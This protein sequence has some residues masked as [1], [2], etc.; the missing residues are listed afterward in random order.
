[1]H[2]DII[3][4]YHTCRSTN[5]VISKPTQMDTSNF[6]LKLNTNRKVEVYEFIVHSH[7]FSACIE[8]TEQNR[9]IFVYFESIFGALAMDGR[10]MQNRETGVCWGV[11]NPYEHVV[12]LMDG[13]TIHQPSVTVA[14]NSIAQTENNAQLDYSGIIPG[15]WRARKSHTY[16][17]KLELWFAQT[18][19]GCTRSWLVVSENKFTF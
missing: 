4:K 19:S 18:A 2:Y 14:D 5:A 17:R 10:V 15:K 16:G 1:M 3:F 11:N 13:Q 12:A 8:R 9:S 6:H 7:K